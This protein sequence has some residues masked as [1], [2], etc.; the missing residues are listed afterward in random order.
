MYQ[1]TVYQNIL[2]DM[3]ADLGW[4]FGLVSLDQC[5]CAT[6]DLVSTK[7][8]DRLRAGNPRWM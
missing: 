3:L 4:R 7:V 8:G 6:S 2:T 1:Q 5:S